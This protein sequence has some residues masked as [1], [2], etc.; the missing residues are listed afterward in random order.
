[1]GNHRQLEELKAQY[2]LRRMRWERETARYRAHAL[3]IR[4]Q[5][6]EGFAY[7]RRHVL[8]ISKAKC[9]RMC[10]V[11]RQTVTRWENPQ[12]TALPDVG[13]IGLLA[14]VYG[15]EVLIHGRAVFG[16]E[17]VQDEPRA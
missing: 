10:G 6:S 4:R 8:R 11:S 15:Y 3:P 9:A 2:A 5:A 17:A 1:M 14:H 12:E 7:V 16:L 13:H